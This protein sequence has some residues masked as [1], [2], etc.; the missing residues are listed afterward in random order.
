MAPR[1]MGHSPALSRR[2]LPRRVSIGSMSAASR[3]AACSAAQRDRVPIGLRGGTSGTSGTPNRACL[4]PIIIGAYA[5]YTRLGRVQSPRCEFPGAASWAATCG[6]I[7]SALLSTAVAPLGGVVRFAGVFFRPRVMPL[8]GFTVVV[9][10]VW[11]AGRGV[12]APLP[13]LFLGSV[14]R[15]CHRR[16]LA[17][18]C[19]CCCRQGR[20]GRPV[21]HGQ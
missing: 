2:S 1:Q 13:A 20:Y 15:H 6:A 11:F 19:F 10:V 9:L 4:F 21:T 14:A 12:K 3:A 5:Y 17:H 16:R 7:P 8:R 18:C